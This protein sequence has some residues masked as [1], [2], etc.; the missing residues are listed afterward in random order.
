MGTPLLRLGCRV[1]CSVQGWERC[2]LRAARRLEHSIEQGPSRAAK[3]ARETDCLG[4]NRVTTRQREALSKGMGE[5]FG[6]DVLPS[7]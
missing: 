7:S 5:P 2:T 6:V 1:G 4:R 3:R